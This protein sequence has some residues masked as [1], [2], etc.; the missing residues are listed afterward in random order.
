MQPGYRLQ[1]EQ[2]RAR[3][4][5]LFV[6]SDDHFFSFLGPFFVAKA[7]TMLLDVR[8]YGKRSHHLLKL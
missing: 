4:T 8:G 5:E 7:I 2:R 3:Q 1:Q 6:S